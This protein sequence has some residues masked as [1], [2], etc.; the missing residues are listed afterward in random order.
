MKAGGGLMTDAE[1]TKTGQGNAAAQ[2]GIPA[3][4]TIL[5]I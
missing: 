4:I 2:G 3:H 1:I 5:I